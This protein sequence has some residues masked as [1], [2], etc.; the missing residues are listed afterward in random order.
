M[1]L[2]ESI[3][4]I[5][6]LTADD[7]SLVAAAIAAETARQSIRALGSSANLALV[8][9]VCSKI[10]RARCGKIQLSPVQ[11]A[12][13]DALVTDSYIKAHEGKVSIEQAKIILKGL[14]MPIFKGSRKGA[15]VFEQLKA[16]HSRNKQALANVTRDLTEFE[17]ANAAYRAEAKSLFHRVSSSGLDPES[18]EVLHTMRRA[19]AAEA[20]AESTANT[21]AYLREAFATALQ[22]QRAIENQLHVHALTEEISKIERN[23]QSVIDRYTQENGPFT[24]ATV[25]ANIS[26]LLTN[27]PTPPVE[28]DDTL[29]TNLV[30]AQRAKELQAEYRERKGGK[31]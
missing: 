15:K 1:V 9:K 19:S 25:D 5:S 30:L 12:W 8:S 28:D 18:S 3:F 14:P 26:D 13:L 16:D 31:G 22:R 11:L 27:A 21:I 17:N 29:M 24:T 2:S 23:N 20:G 6:V 10:Y 7:D 4:E